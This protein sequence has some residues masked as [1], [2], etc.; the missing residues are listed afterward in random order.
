MNAVK[1][2]NIT[3]R[4]AN[5]RIGFVKKQCFV[6]RLIVVVVVVLCFIYVQSTPAQKILWETG[7]EKYPPRNRR[8][9][10]N[11]STDTVKTGEKSLEIFSKKQDKVD[12][13]GK[14][15]ITDK[16]IVSVEFWVYIESGG[17]SFG[18]SV[19]STER[20]IDNQTGG[21]YIDW[22][23]DSIRCHVNHEDSW[24]EISPF[25]VNEWNYVRIV[26]DFE[27]NMFDF[28]IADN[29]EE[30]LDAQPKKDL[31]FR[32][33]ALVP[34]AKGFVFFAEAMKARGYIDN[35]LI[36]EGKEPFDLANRSTEKLPTLWGRLKQ[37]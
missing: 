29:R 26:T 23:A 22:E 21:P 3:R 11:T 4:D 34:R 28:Y 30:A 19:I 8:D 20:W 17:Q 31:P 32:E 36:Y 37:E 15:L 10:F 12:S 35:L 5:K 16:P 9:A 25:A 13:F 27:K 6:S 33:D 2:I 14:K 18:I 1:I 7:F 24:R